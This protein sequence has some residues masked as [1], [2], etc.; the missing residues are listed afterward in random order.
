MSWV[1][2]TG[3]SGG[4]GRAI[5]R[6]FV[7]EG[8]RVLGV[9]HMKHQSDG[10]DFL[11]C[12]LGIYAVDENYRV[13]VDEK[14]KECTGDN[15]KVLVNNAALQVVKPFM[16]ISAQEYHK[17]MNVNVTAPYLL[18]QSLLPVLKSQSGAIV[19]IASIH[20]A[21]TKP[22]FS[23]Y[24]ISKSAMIGMTRALAVEIGGSVRVNALAPAAVETEMLVA[25]FKGKE[26]QYELLKGMHPVGRIGSVEEV[27][28]AVFFLARAELPFLNGA[29]IGIDGG[30]LGRLHDPA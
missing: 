19:N 23:A 30:I 7:H 8:Y 12:D 3:S 16:E 25:G 13:L 22:N 21:L 6:R 15:V 29:V 9:D 28:E 18:S 20:A 27:A 24:A 10:V 4:I 26:A 14:I 11:E 1:I 17:V 5:C 2:V